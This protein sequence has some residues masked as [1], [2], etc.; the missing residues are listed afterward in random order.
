MS[1]RKHH[2]K[3][4]IKRGDND[5][6]GWQIDN[7]DGDSAKAPSALSPRFFNMAVRFLGYT[8]TEAGFRMI[9]QLDAEYE[10][11]LRMKQKKTTSD[12]D[13]EREDVR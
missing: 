11:L 9:A 7:G 10:D 3:K 6:D 1:W 13:F 8:H 2:T 5:D 12:E 4:R